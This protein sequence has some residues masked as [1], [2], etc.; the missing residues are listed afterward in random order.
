MQ[1]K[2]A[3]TCSNLWPKGKKNPIKSNHP[4]SLLKNNRMVPLQVCQWFQGSLTH[5][6]AKRRKALSP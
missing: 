3:E 5:A 2:H 6:V 4:T 1:L